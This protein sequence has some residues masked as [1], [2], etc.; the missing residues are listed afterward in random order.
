MTSTTDTER[1]I[2]MFA[3]P[4]TS[5]SGAFLKTTFQNVELA[6]SEG[7]QIPASLLREPIHRERVQPRSE[8]G[9]RAQRCPRNHRRRRRRRT[10]RGRRCSDACWQCAGPA[11]G[12]S[13]VEW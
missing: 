9:G 2:E 6:F 13:R 4:E 11:S 10:I 7:D 3:N 1:Y 12:H 8:V 5:P